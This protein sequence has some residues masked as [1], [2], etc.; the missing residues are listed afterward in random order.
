[1]D[2]CPLRGADVISFF[3]PGDPRSQ[4]SLRAIA[5]GVVAHPDGLRAWRACVRLK[6]REAMQGRPPYDGPAVLGVAFLLRRK[7]GRRMLP[8]AQEDRDLDKLLRA[9]GDAL[10]Q[11]ILVDDARI[12]AGWQVKLYADSLGEEPGALIQVDALETGERPL[13]AVARLVATKGGSNP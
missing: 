2:R 10:T 7:R 1:M 12:V 3:V 6:A 4:G 5:P 13:D 9:I 11:T 8:W